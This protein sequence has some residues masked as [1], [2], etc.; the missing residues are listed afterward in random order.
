MAKSDA[1]RCKAQHGTGKA[2]RG[3]EAKPQQGAWQ[4]PTRCEAASNAG[5][6]ETDLKIDTAKRRT[7]VACLSGNGSDS[8]GELGRV[9]WDRIIE[10]QTKQNPSKT[11]ESI[12]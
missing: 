7:N 3:S 2:Q 6:S 12:E 9:L 10:R 4:S 5:Q 1:V 11:K 8:G